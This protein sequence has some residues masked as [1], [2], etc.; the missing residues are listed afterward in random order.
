MLVVCEMMKQ[1]HPN[2]KVNWGKMIETL[3]LANAPISCIEYL[4]ETG[5]NSFEDDTA[6]CMVDWE[7]MV[8]IL[9]SSFQRSSPQFHKDVH[10]LLPSQEVPFTNVCSPNG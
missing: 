2:Y 1:L 9:C 10:N 6:L 8:D 5:I 4:I 3:C 7:K